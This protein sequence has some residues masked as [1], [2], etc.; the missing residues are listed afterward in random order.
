MRPNFQQTRLITHRQEFLDPYG[1]SWSFCLAAASCCASRNVDPTLAPSLISFARNAEII[2]HINAKFCVCADQRRFNTSP[3]PT[4]V[5]LEVD[6]QMTL[7]KYI[8]R[9]ARHLSEGSRNLC[10]LCSHCW[11]KK[12]MLFD[13]IVFGVCFRRWGVLSGSYSPSYCIL[14][15]T[16]LDKCFGRVSLRVEGS[17]NEAPVGCKTW[18]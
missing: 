5:I 16:H 7:T 13:K 11:K 1:N 18:K 6:L 9:L 17:R 14:T 3:P 15:I 12:K 4:P 8:C 2:S 10:I